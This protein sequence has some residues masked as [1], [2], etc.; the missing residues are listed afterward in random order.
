MT[1]LTLGKVKF[2][3]R[4]TYAIANTYSKGDIVQY[5]SQSY[6]YKND[7]SKSYSPLFLDTSYAGTISSLAANVYTVTITLSS[8][9]TSANAYILRAIEVQA[10]VCWADYLYLKY[11]RGIIIN[12]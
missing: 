7:T 10:K 4:G 6:I 9:L 12:S 11:Y 1:T 5:A 2:V 8:A 3:N